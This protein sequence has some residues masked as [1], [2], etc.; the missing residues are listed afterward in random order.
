[1]TTTVIPVSQ[2]EKPK[3]PTWYEIPRSPNQPACA[4][5]WRPD[6][7]KS[8]R[9]RVSIHRPTSASETRSA[10]EPAQKRDHG[11]SQ[12]RS[13][14][15]AGRRISAVVIASPHRDEDDDED[16]E[17]AGD[18]ESVVPEEPCLRPGHAAGRVAD[19]ASELRDRAAD[20]EPF[21]DSAEEPPRGDR[22]AVED[23]VVRLVEVELVLQDALRERE[24]G[25]GEPAAGI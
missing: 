20:D 12:T 7:E 22:R 4:P 9:T 15:P 17:A 3:R 11:R 13:A 18:R 24:A 19:A 2:S 23:E 6:R 14:P 21:D 25:H 10:N 16:G 8:K 1:M 5:S